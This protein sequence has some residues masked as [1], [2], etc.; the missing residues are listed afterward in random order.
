MQRLF[1]KQPSVGPQ[2]NDSRNSSVASRSRPTV[3]LSP[4]Y[5]GSLP[6]FSSSVSPS[7]KTEVPKFV[8]VATVKP[9][10]NTEVQRPSFT[11]RASESDRLSGF[12]NSWQSDVSGK[13][14]ALLGFF[15][16]IFSF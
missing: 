12:S 7:V 8:T 14:A 2:S 5:S 3:S 6:K 4:M 1:P 9:V 15:S 16:I 13:S 11:G 10:P